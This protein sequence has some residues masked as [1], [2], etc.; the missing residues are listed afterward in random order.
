MFYIFGHKNP[1]SNSICRMFFAIGWPC[2]LV[3]KITSSSS[4]LGK[5][6]IHNFPILQV[7]QAPREALDAQCHNA[8][9]DAESLREKYW[10]HGETQRWR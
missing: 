10:T 1:D 4:R 3:K 9:F 5:L 6:T 8:N 7:M 2:Y